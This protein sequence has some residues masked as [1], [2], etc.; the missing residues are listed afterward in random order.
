MCHASPTHNRSIDAHCAL[1]RVRGDVV[2]GCE[3][4]IEHDGVVMERVHVIRTPIRE[5]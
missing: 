5:L 2:H 1:R 3:H 4:A